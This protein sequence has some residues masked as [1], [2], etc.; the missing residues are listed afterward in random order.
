MNQVVV[1]QCLH[2]EQ[3]E[4]YS[5]GD[6]TFEDGVTHVPTPH[7][8][9]LALALLEVASSHYAPPRTT[10]EHPPT[11][12]HL[13]VNVHDANQACNPTDGGYKP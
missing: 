9:A 8:Q 7:R 2:H 12:F 5:T 13:I 6:I 1:F 3:R 10:L 4:V 11:G